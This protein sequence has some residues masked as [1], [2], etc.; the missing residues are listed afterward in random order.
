MLW[1]GCLL[2][3]CLIPVGRVSGDGL[4]YAARFTAGSW[5]WNPNHLLFE[6]GGASWHWLFAAAGSTRPVVDQLKTLS[7]AAGA[8][9]AALFRYCLAPRL[10]GRRWSANY[11]TAWMV[12]GSTYSRM[13]LS[14]KFEM[15]QMPLLVGLAAALLLYLERPGFLRAAAAGAAAGGAALFF[16]ANALLG[17]T[18]AVALG[19]LHAVRREWSMAVRAS[20]GTLAG[21]LLVALPV[22]GAT[23]WLTAPDRSLASW[24]F[25][26]AGGSAPM[27]VALV[28]GTSWNPQEVATAAARATYGAASAAVDLE[29][30]VAAVRDEGS[31]GRATVIAVAWLLSAATLAAGLRQALRRAAEP[32]A[33]AALLLQAV[34]WP[35]VLG[36]GLYWNSSDDQFYFQLAVPFAALV[37]LLPARGR[38]AA[39]VVLCGA[40]A[41]AWNASD[42]A[43]RFILY[44]RAAYSAALEQAIAGAG[45]IVTP[46]YD[47]A[48]FL[49]ALAGKRVEAE[50][51]SI[52]ELALEGPPE[53]GLEHL[54]SAVRH[55]LATGRRIDLVDVYDGP[56]LGP[57]WKFLHRLGYE[58]A[59]LVRSLAP[60]A[61]DP[62]P[63][64]VGPFLVRSARP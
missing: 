32:S 22:L 44:P 63:R 25:G 17:V 36:F 34:W 61:V 40:A 11:A 5:K 47:E 54:S 52:T 56:P 31:P 4:G 45:L 50:R 41:L 7:T 53:Q 37:A 51:L 9:A 30:A 59:A 23:W 27:R 3:L 60:F 43:R 33:Q 8:L 12:L 38:G 42:I 6:P 64:R 21:L 20:S 2:L 48:A 19:V 16:I 35:A 57:P 14:D 46:G 55:C 39:A 58:R 18:A 10:A 15:I 24:L 1:L 13:M 62:E 29:P 49:L 28:Y 26:Y